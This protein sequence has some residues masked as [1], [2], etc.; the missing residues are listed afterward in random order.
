MRMMGQQD[1]VVAIRGIREPVGA[2]VR[3]PSYRCDR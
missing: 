1:S 3:G 2:P